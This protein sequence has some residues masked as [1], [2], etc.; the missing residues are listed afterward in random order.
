MPVGVCEFDSHLPHRNR[1]QIDSEAD[2][3]LFLA[4]FWRDDMISFVSLCTLDSE[5]LVGMNSNQRF[6]Q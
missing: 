1:L 5:L 6:F 3:L 4:T 2:F